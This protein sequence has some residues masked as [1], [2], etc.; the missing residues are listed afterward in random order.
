MRFISTAILGAIL[1]TGLFAQDDKI[2]DRFGVAANLDFYPQ[3]SPKATLASIMKAIK[4]E[5]LDYLVAHLMEPA[6]VD[7]RMKETRTTLAKMQ[8]EIAAHLK[9]D[10][11]F[12]NDLKAFSLTGEIVENDQTAVIKQKDINDRAIYMK[13]IGSRWYMEN[14]RSAVE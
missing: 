14:R 9:Q 11:E 7:K 12:L 2:P 4:N 5:R 3:G 10:S 8:A 13:R 6:Y 1:A